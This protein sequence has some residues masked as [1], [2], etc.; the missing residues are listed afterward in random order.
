MYSI[1]QKNQ[2]P[3]KYLMFFAGCKIY[4]FVSSTA[5]LAEIWSLA[6]ISYDR[7]QTI[8]YPLNNLKRIKK[9]QV[10]INLRKI[11]SRAIC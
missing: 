10:T 9:S 8:L 6:A 4:G 2:L 11:I 3:N 1:F 5:A 7:L